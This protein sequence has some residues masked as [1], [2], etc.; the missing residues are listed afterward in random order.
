MTPE[1]SP[2]AVD[3]V[4]HECPPGDENMTPCCNRTP[5]ELP[6]TDRMTVDRSLV[7]CVGPPVQ[8]RTRLGGAFCWSGLVAEIA[9]DRAGGSETGVNAPNPWTPTDPEEA[10]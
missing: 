1:T 9:A 10:A 4:I 5:F 8:V 6:R 3:S 2:A 7:T